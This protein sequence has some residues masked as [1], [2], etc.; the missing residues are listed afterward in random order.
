MTRTFTFKWFTAY[1]NEAVV[2][3]S[4]AFPATRTTKM[5]PRPWSKMISVG[6]R[7]S[8]QPRMAT[9]GN[10]FEM[11]AR[12]SKALLSGRTAEPV[13]KR[14]LPRCNSARTSAGEREATL[15]CSASAWA[16]AS[17]MEKPSQPTMSIAGFGAATRC[18][19]GGG[20]CC[21]GCVCC[22]CCCCCSFR[23]VGLLSMLAKDDV[24]AVP[25]ATP[26]TLA[27]PT[28]MPST[29]AARWLGREGVVRKMWPRRPALRM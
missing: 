1:C 23:G 27:T 6:T 11:R 20:I 4:K 8:E 24:H 25:S 9:E 22:C 7:E 28:A 26:E 16:R 13:Q 18:C 5:S 10:C 29:M 12:R 15:L 17:C 19:A 21:G 2:P 14:A 3:T